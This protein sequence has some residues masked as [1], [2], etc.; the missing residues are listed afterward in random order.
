[1]GTEML[2]PGGNKLIVEEKPELSQSLGR[3]QMDTEVLLS[4]GG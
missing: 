1:M 2:S 3:S 4:W